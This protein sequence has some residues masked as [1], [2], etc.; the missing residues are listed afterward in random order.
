[1]IDFQIV[2]IAAIAQPKK[3]QQSFFGQ[4]TQPSD[5]SSLHLVGGSEHFLFFQC[6]PYMGNNHPK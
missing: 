4:Q 5:F 6:F 3:S 2:R 1:M